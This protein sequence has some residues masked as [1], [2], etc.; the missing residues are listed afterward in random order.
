MEPE[1]SALGVAASWKEDVRA[2]REG[3]VGGTDVTKPIGD[4]ILR[5]F[6]GHGRKL[7]YCCD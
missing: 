6:K 1:I 4:Q 7:G 3:P 5:C 2:N